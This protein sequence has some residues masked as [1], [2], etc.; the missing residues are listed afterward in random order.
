MHAEARVEDVGEVCSGHESHTRAVHLSNNRLEL[1]H[2]RASFG[3]HCRRVMAQRLED[4]GGLPPRGCGDVLVTW[5][6]RAFKP[7]V[8]PPPRDQRGIH[9]GA[10]ASERGEELLRR[11]R[12]PPPT[13]SFWQRI[14]IQ[15]RSEGSLEQRFDVFD[16]GLARVRRFYRRDGHR[17]VAHERQ[18]QPFGFFCHCK[19]RVARRTAM[20]L[21]QIDAGF[22]ECPDGRARIGGVRDRELRSYA[23]AHRAVMPSVVDVTDQYANNRAEVSYQPTRQRARQ[24]RRFKSAT[25]D[26]ACKKSGRGGTH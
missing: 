18:R 10:V 21:D 26:P 7:R 12:S 6:A 20:H 22:L 11:R 9:N 5:V 19:V 3:Q 1:T 15:R 24:M 25:L 2:Q 16:G 23:A 17:Y 13:D 14:A 4:L 8:D